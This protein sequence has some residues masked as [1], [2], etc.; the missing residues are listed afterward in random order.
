MTQKTV[1]TTLLTKI[2]TVYGTDP[3][4]T[5]AANAI[6]FRNARLT[7][8]ELDLQGRET[9]RPFLG[10]AEALVAGKWMRLEVEVELAGG[11]AAGTAPP[12]GVL[13]RA[14]GMGETINAGVS[15]VYKPISASEESATHYCNYDGVLH[16]SVG[17]RGTWGVRMEARRIPVLVFTFTGLFVAVADGTLPSLTLTAWTKPL[18]VNNTNTTTFSLHSYAAI[19]RSFSLDANNEVAY[20]NLVGTERVIFTDREFK[21]KAQV[22]SMLVATKDYWSLA[23]AGTLGALSVVHGTAAG[24]IVTIGSSTV[25]LT[26]VGHAEF[27]NIRMLDIDLGLVP[28]N[29]GNDEVTITVT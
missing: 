7:A 11:G 4:P 24:N 3:T 28:S 13:M 20:Q 8:L 6:L 2:E 22:E 18:P 1:R 14:C 17:A 5:G 16:K 25:Q 29:T 19:M 12:W 9:V 27:D 26:G 15:A 10:K 23:T 21:G